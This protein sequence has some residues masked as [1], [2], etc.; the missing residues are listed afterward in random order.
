VSQI[1]DLSKRLGRAR[2]LPSVLTASHDAFDGIRMAIRGRER[3][4]SGLFAA[5]VMSAAAAIDGRDA[6]TR[7]P[8][9]P[10]SAMRGDDGVQ[11][12]VGA[13]AGARDL[14]GELARLAGLL[15]GRLAE[16]EQAAVGRGDQDACAKA[17]ACAREIHTLLA[18][19]AR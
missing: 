9:L 13:A 12:A 14:A 8:S 11:R 3:P 1:S 2:D 4:A 6:I 7:A 19:A 18:E 17:A 16:A 10:L 15:A 5:L